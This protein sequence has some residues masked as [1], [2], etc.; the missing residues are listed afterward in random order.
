MSKE[1]TKKRQSKND[2]P[3]YNVKGEIIGYAPA[4]GNFTDVPAPAASGRRPDNDDLAPSDSGD[5]A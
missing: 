1:I 2:E 5:I 3:V 4:D